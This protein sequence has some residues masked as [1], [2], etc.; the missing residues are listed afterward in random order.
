MGGS[1][2]VTSATAAPGMSIHSL[3]KMLCQ[4]T[5]DSTPPGRSAV[6]TLAKA[7]TGSV[8]NITPKRE[9]AAS[10]RDSPKS[11]TWMSAYTNSTFPMPSR[12]ARSRPR[13]S[14]SAEMSTPTACPP[15]PAR[16]TSSSVVLPVPQPRSTTLR[17]GSN[18][19][20]SMASSPGGPATAS[21]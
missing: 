3:S 14:I 12:A 9:Y 18:S 17:P 21:S 6:P 19:R 20:R 7:V 10:N 11:W 8:K 5:N 13:A 2:P 16:D 15:G 1:D 4:Q